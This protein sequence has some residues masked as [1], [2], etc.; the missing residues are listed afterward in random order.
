M[1][2]GCSFAK[3]VLVLL[4][5][6]FGATQAF[7]ATTTYFCDKQM[8]ITD[9][10][11]KGTGDATKYTITVSARSSATTNT[12]TIK[13]E[14]A[15]VATISFSYSVEN[16]TAFTIDGASATASGTYSKTFTAKEESVI[17]LTTKGS[18]F[19]QKTA[20][21]TLTD[22][23][24]VVAGTVSETTFVFDDTLGTVTVAGEAVANGAV[25]TLEDSPVEVVATPVSGATFVA[26]VDA[27][28]RI[29]SKQPTYTQQPK[30]KV[31][32]KALFNKNTPHF[33]VDD[34]FIFNDLN[35]AVGKPGAK[36]V[37]LLCDGTLRAGEYTIPS[38][39][40]LLIPFDDAHTLYTTKNESTSGS[41]VKPTPYRTLTLADGVNITINGAI[42]LSAKQSSSIKYHGSPVSKYGNMV[43]QQ[44]SSI[45]VNN[46]G[47]LYVWGYITGSGEITAKSGATV[48]EDFQVRDFRGGQMTSEMINNSNR[49]FPMSQYYVQNIEVPLT[50]EAGAVENGYMWVYISG[51]SQLLGDQGSEI[52]FIGPNGMFRIQSGSVIKDYDES[53]DRLVIRINGDMGMAPLS[54]SMKLSLAGTQT[55]KSENYTLPVNSNVTLHVNKGSTIN[56]SQD[57]ALLPGGEIYI[58]EGATCNFSANAKV[59]LYDSEDWGNY[60]SPQ[61]LPVMPVNYAPGAKYTRTAADLVDAKVYVAGTIDSLNGFVY[62]TEKGASV[63]GGEGGLVQLKTDTQTTKTYQVTQNSN[64]S[65][66]YPEIPVT[67]AW[68]QNADGTYVDP[69]VLGDCCDT[70]QYTDGVWT[71]QNT[72]HTETVIPGVAATCDEAGLSD[73]VYCSS[74]NTIIIEQQTVPALGHNYQQIIPGDK[75]NH[76][77]VCANDASHIELEPHT[78]VGM[79]CTGCGCDKIVTDTTYTISGETILVAPALAVNIAGDTQIIIATIGANEQV[80]QTS[81]TTVDKLGEVSFASSG[82]IKIKVFAWNGFN[83]LKPVSVAEEILVN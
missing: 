44:G 60:C 4:I 46:G 83:Y 62:T 51:V 77:K 66:A 68:L 12:I 15:S 21:L 13:N 39:V 54:L 33:L 32:A 81:V 5:A 71:P 38:G 37:V 14:G 73:G 40:T 43:M 36:K 11:S 75:T 19:S 24:Y 3:I 70:Y 80:L 23:S 2:K 47:N 45:T 42:S 57:L 52:P 29:I 76:Q 25:V 22:I 82:V 72:T 61:N 48:Y 78:F 31:T 65:V 16:Q 17:K 10:S 1:R 41:Y 20:T 8:S 34:T 79:T 64:E 30:G 27:D 56:I 58:Y 49:V 50:L 55:I 18:L 53:T 59:Y 9:S 74:C 28:G 6:L 26:W 63:C 69:E 35:E 7:A 67:T